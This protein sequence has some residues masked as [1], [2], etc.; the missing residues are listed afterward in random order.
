MTQKFLHRLEINASRPKVGCQ[1]VTEAV[2][3]NRL[4][5][6]PGALESRTDDFLE[7]GVR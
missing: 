7:Q 6:D 3:T 2:P 1:G 4:A 5:L